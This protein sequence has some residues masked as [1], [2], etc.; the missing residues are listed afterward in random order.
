[1]WIDIHAHLDRLS[2][3]ELEQRVAEAAVAGVSVIVST[4]TDLASAETVAK[5]CSHYD[6]LYGTAGIS[7]FDSIHLPAHWESRLKAQLLCRG[8][9]AVGEI[10]LDCANSTYPSLEIQRPPF[11]KQ[12]AIAQELDMPAIVHS[13]G[14]EIPVMETCQSIGNKKVIFHCFTGSRDILERILEAGYC[15]SF[16]GIVTFDSSIRRL[17]RH[18]P[19]DRLFIETD[20][21]YLTPAPFRGQKNHPALVVHTGETVAREKNISAEILQEA[22]AHNFARLFLS[23]GAVAEKCV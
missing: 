5:Q 19:L 1:M 18:V 16:S 20:S 7:P 14:A 11:E 23:R 3:T 17:I 13:R 8:I 12:L 21:P 10:G 2:E 4:A 22:L 15:I 6:T 9:L